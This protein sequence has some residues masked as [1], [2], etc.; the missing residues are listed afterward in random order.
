MRNSS[1]SPQD[2]L[3]YHSRHSYYQ[4]R[5]RRASSCQEYEVKLLSPLGLLANE[6][7]AFLYSFQ[8]LVVAVNRISRE[9]SKMPVRV[10]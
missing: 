1:A 2:T 10:F 5:T 8:E 7:G 4:Q 9:K 6:G 3:A